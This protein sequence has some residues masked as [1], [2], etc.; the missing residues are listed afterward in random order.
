MRFERR[1]SADSGRAGL[2]RPFLWTLTGDAASKI[3]ILLTSLVAVRSL[4]PVE[5]G[6]YLGLAATTILAASMWDLGVSSVVTRELAAQRT[7]TRRALAR[8]AAL[9]ARALP[10]WALSFSVGATIL[11]RSGEASAFAL[12]AFGA[13][14]LVFATHTITLSV[15]R[16]HLQ[17]RP[18]AA[19]LAAGRW[20]TAALSLLALPTVGLDDG[21]LVL[22]FAL[23][24]GEATTLIASI[25]AIASHARAGS[26]GRSALGPGTSTIGFRVAFPFAANSVLNLAYNRFDIIVLAALSTPQQLGLYAPASRIQDA[27][28]LV[29]VVIST[30]GLPLVARMWQSGRGAEATRA[31]LRTMMVLGVV[32]SLPATILVFVYAEDLIS[33]VLGQDYVGASTATRILIW[34]LPFAALTSPLIVALAGADRASDTTRIFLA[35]FLVAMTMHASLDWWWGATGAAVASL[36]REPAALL[37][38]LFYAR[39]AGLLGRWGQ[40]VRP[41]ATLVPKS[42]RRS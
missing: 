35:A 12:V 24:A 31:L 42:S 21:L 18:A 39:A 11:A 13:A 40:P 9:R 20:T 33:L 41:R 29:P 15:L 2:V 30:I 4:P 26:D 38:A 3:A 1:D 23:L 25:G 16:A 37:V 17:F 7:T 8:S 34:F 28:Y 14:S 6:V 22:A 5:F 32:L 36:S 10:I 27:L 19:A